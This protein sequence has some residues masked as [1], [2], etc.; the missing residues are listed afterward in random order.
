MLVITASDS[1]NDET[2][3]RRRAGHLYALVGVIDHNGRGE[4]KIA[5]VKLMMPS[6]RSN[7]QMEESAMHT[8]ICIRV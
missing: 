8:W 4:E 7:L 5:R 2:W 3:G 6:Q 1:S